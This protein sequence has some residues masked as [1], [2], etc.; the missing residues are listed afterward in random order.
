MVGPVGVA[1]GS[2]LS[3]VAYSRAVEAAVKVAKGGVGREHSREWGDAA[4]RLL[5]SRS[6]SPLALL[7]AF[8]A[9]RKVGVVGELES[10]GLGSVGSLVSVAQSLLQSLKLVTAGFCSGPTAVAAAAPVVQVVVEALGAFTRGEKDAGVSETRKKKLWKSLRKVMLEVSGFIS[11]CHHKDAPVVNGLFKAPSVNLGLDI[12][13]SEGADFS[14]LFPFASQLK[15]DGFLNSIESVLYLGEVVETEVA[16]LRLVAEVLERRSSASV[17]K[18]D[19]LEKKLKHD[20]VVYARFLGSSSVILDMLLDAPLQ[21]GGILAESEE[22]MLRDVLG[23]MAVAGVPNSGVFEEDRGALSAGDSAGRESVAF[24]K[25]VMIARQLAGEFRSRGEYLRAS[26]LVAGLHRRGAPAELGE[27]LGERGSLRVLISTAV[28]GKQQDLVE[29]LLNAS[30][31]DFN[32]VLDKAYIERPKTDSVEDVPAASMDLE[33][34][35]EDDESLFFIDT[36]KTYHK[37]AADTGF[38]ADQEFVVA[39]G[40]IQADTKGDVLFDRSEQLER[41]RTRV[42]G[43]GKVAKAKQRKNANGAK[44]GGDLSDS[45]DMSE[46]DSEEESSMSE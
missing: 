26:D 42:G 10:G 21:V 46:D 40:N 43:K 39:A 5:Q 16:L 29:W 17:A 9:F 14:S 4:L 11:L 3:S 2:L 27:W 1:R 22:A 12:W 15:V 33:E 36:S 20:V 30:K 28:L 18:K 8:L 23:E 6:N 32:V 41:K 44:A 13:L 25:R 38:D 34:G 37:D 24:L 45:E 35:G 31:A 7:W 19:E